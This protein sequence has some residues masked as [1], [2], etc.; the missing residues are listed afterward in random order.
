MSASDADLLNSTATVTTALAR[1]TR[2]A[3]ERLTLLI[4]RMTYIAF[5]F[6]IACFYFAQTYLQILNQNNLWKPHGITHPGSALGFA[7]ML[8]IEIGGLVYFWAQW[9][10]LY[11]RN[12]GRLATGLWVA[13]ACGLISV[14]LHII[15]FYKL[16]FG[17]TD[18]GYAS[19]FIGTEGVFTGM[20]IL[21]VIVLFGMAN[22]AR[23]GLF[24]TSGIAV[25]AFGEWW[26]WI[27]G[28]ALLNF[29]ALYVQ[30]FFPI[31]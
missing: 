16:G 11:R 6:F 4:V 9:S 30:P 8:L 21:T 25:E 26:G 13:A 5:S 19:V 31:A 18:G 12:F 10:G 15:E 24:T 2:T 23:L 17:P 22:R 27:A 29:L 1:H 7:E 20:L 14:I 28:V 3:D